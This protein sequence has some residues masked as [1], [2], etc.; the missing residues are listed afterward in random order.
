MVG[1]PKYGI[2][3]IVAITII[4]NYTVEHKKRDNIDLQKMPLTIP[5]NKTGAFIG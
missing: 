5:C 1:I 2:I 3:R 4:A